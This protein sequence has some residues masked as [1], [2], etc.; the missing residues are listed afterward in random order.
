[1]GRFRRAVEQQDLW[2]KFV[3]KL[4]EQNFGEEAA[5]AVRRDKPG[6]DTLCRTAAARR[7]GPTLRRAGRRGTGPRRQRGESRSRQPADMAV[8]VAGPPKSK[9]VATVAHRCTS[10]RAYRGAPVV[11]RG[12]AR[13]APPCPTTSCVLGILLANQDTELTQNHSGRK[14][15]SRNSWGP[16][17]VVWRSLPYLTLPYRAIACHVKGTVVH[18]VGSH[19]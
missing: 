10:T 9:V 17:Q 8:V 2:H 12:D 13:V 14:A 7:R 1:M 11:R 3:D 16:C 6:P 19:A 18:S 5:P 15:A 4:V